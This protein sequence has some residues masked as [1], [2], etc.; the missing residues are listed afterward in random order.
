MIVKLQAVGQ[1][2]QDLERLYRLLSF[3]PGIFH[4]MEIGHAS[5]KEGTGTQYEF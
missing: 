4:K 1:P 2:S 5:G 3:R